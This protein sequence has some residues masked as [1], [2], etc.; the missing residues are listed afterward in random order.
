MHFEHRHA[1]MDREIG[2]RRVFE[3]LTKLF[4]IKKDGDGETKKKLDKTQ[5]KLLSLPSLRKSLNKEKVL[6]GGQLR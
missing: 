6:R 1:G 2:K 5:L 4:D 3:M